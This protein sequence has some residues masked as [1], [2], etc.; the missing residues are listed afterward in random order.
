MIKK[1]MNKIRSIKFNYLQVKKTNNKI[2]KNNNKN[3][4][5]IN[6]VKKKLNSQMN[7]IRAHSSN[8]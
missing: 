4:N 5:K 1:V 8:N 7:K 6:K 3:N 2:N